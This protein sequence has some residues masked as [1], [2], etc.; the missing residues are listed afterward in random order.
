MKKIFFVKLGLASIISSTAFADLKCIVPGDVETPTVSVEFH[1]N[2]HVTVELYG[3]S[4]NTFK[5]IYEQSHMSAELT[6][7]VDQ[8]TWKDMPNSLQL[9][10]HLI[11]ADAGYFFELVGL[12]VGTVKFSE[13]KNCS[14]I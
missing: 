13:H 11:K 6:K 10:Q 5:A 7:V 12:P 8:S 9:S 14:E 4:R 3:H 1:S 2:N